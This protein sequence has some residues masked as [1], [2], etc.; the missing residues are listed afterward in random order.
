LRND[1][2]DCWRDREDELAGDA[3]VLEAYGLAAVGGDPAVVPIWA[4]EGID[5]ITELS[6]A[7]DLVSTLVTEAEDAIARLGRC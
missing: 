3:A 5:L 1:F 2:L 4:G 7:S 6:S